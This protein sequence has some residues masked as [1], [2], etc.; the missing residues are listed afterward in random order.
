MTPFKIY[1]LQAQVYA[2]ALFFWIECVVKRKMIVTQFTSGSIASIPNLG[3]KAFL[4]SVTTE[5]II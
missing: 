3:C 4:A 1:P 5:L 2:C